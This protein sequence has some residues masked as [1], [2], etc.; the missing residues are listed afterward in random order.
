MTSPGLLF[1]ETVT[2]TLAMTEVELSSMTKAELSL[3]RE[4]LSLL[5]RTDGAFSIP[6]V[7]ISSQSSGFVRLADFVCLSSSAS[8][9]ASTL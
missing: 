6:F 9:I 5:S 3:L 7:L 4:V 1:V 2:T 8:R